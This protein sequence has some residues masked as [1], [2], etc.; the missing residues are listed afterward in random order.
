LE[1]NQ[2]FLNRYNYIK[3]KMQVIDNGVGISEEGLKNMF[4]DFGSLGEHAKMNSRGTGL[5]L[6]ICKNLIEK[7]GGSIVVSSVKDK[8]TTFTVEM[9]EVQ[10]IGDDKRELFGLQEAAKLD[11]LI[12]KE[13]AI[14]LKM[15]KIAERNS[16]SEEGES[17]NMVSNDMIR[18]SQR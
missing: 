10:R 3:F 17:N 11:E 5:G 16:R 12:I 2:K 4:M 13:K 18:V 15:E 6:S 7:M 1:H 9:I 8:G 14:P